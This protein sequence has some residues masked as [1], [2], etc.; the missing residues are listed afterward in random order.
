MSI[1]SLVGPDAPS[2]GSDAPRRWLAIP[3]WETVFVCAVLFLSTNAVVP[4]VFNPQLGSV[5]TANLKVRDPLSHPAWLLIWLVVV[6]MMFRFGGEVFTALMRNPAI[7]VVC[8]LA[9]LSPAWSAVPRS[10]LQAAIELALSTLVGLYVGVRFGTAR[11]VA[12]LGWVT[13][14]ILVLSV[15]FALELPSYGLDHARGGAW[16]GVFGTKNELGRMMVFG[17]VVWAVRIFANE[18]SRLGGTAVVL[19]FALVGLASGSR[20][21]LGVSTLMA[22]VF[23]LI[24]LLSHQSK[25]WVPMKGFVVMGI[26]LSALL[27]LT[28]LNL[29]FTVVGADYTLTG[30]LN[31]WDAVWSAIRVHPWLGYGFDAFWR[32]IQ[33]P[34]LEVW[35]MSQDAPP[36][37]H[38]GFLDMLLALGATGLAVF[39]VAYAVVWRRALALLHRGKGS[40]HTFPLAFLSLLV[41]YN[42]TESSLMG[43]RALDWIV[44]VAVAVAVAKDMAACEVVSRRSHAPPVFVGAETA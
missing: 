22:G 17:G 34:S 35:R 19:G 13:A 6:V 9:L 4:L 41:L 29:L 15:V 26:A 10:T 7:G 33:G 21:A 24:W 18:I 42:L 3:G 43:T 2:V 25:A 12:M 39:V 37:S 8:F 14:T 30:R 38:N 23:V 5:G 31:I 36:H 44:F 28:H 32:G 11:L 27:L 16:R 40:A 1:A 20:T